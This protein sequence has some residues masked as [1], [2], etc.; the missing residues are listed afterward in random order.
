MF[1]NPWLRLIKGSSVVLD[2]NPELYITI[3][4]KGYD[5]REEYGVMPAVGNYANLTAEQVTAI[6]AHERSSW[7]NKAR[8]IPVAEVQKITD[9]IKAG[10]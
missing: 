5:A 9:F 7:G 6:I 2:Y 10:K 3:I 4:M 1:F 8:K